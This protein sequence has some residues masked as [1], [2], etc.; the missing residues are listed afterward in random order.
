[1][2][3]GTALDAF[4]SIDEG[5]DLCAQITKLFALHGSREMRARARMAFLIEDWGIE[6][7]RTE[8]EAQ[9][10]RPIARAGVDAR[11]T[12]KTDH[13][14]ITQQAGAGLYAVGLCVPVG[15]ASAAQLAELA[16][17]ADDYG[18]GEVRFTIDQNVLLV[19]VSDRALPA[20]LGEPLLR[21]LRPDPSPIMRGTVSCIGVDYCNL[22]L[23][24]TKGA[25]RM[26]ANHLE[27]LLHGRDGHGDEKRLRLR[28]VTVNWSGCP[29]ACGNHQAA[30]IGF[31]GGKTRIG[32]EVVETF[33]VFV[34]GRTGTAARAGEKVLE[35][36]PTAEL[37]E[38][39]EALVRAHARG[40]SLVEVAAG[41]A[42]QRA[43]AAAAEAVA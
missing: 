30:D 7:F 19:N 40:E 23:A 29:A 20:L 33:D 39:A 13:L 11:S 41:I 22:A 28:P 34:D 43:A 4:V 37:T 36:I 5:A 17:L 38:V 18:S 2:R 14:G 31:L 3:V 42:S 10:G 32:G 35:K 9:W 16:R 25:A 26:V 12:R 27:T 21:E 8:L 15:R 6:R 1:M 24:E